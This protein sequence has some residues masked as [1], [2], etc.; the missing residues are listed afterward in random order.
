[1][2][3]IESKKKEIMEKENKELKENR[4]EIRYRVFPELSR[5]INNRNKLV[6]IEVALP[7][8][9][10]EDISLKTLPTWFN[11]TGYRGNIEYSANQSWGTIIVPE[12]TKAKYKSG[13]LKI[14]AHI[15]DPYEDAVELKL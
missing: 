13:L 8:V 1:M 3:M 2:A 10:K 6:T 12:K 11:L 9:K 14:T 4:K 7:G 15:K 5:S